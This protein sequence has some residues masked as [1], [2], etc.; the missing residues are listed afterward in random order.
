MVALGLVDGRV[1]LDQHVAGLDA[2]AV[3]DMDRA[4]HAGLERLDHLGAPARGRSCRCAVATISTVPRQAQASATQNRA[5]IGDADRAA[6][7][8]GRRL[9]DLERGRQE[10]QLVRAAG[11]TPVGTRPEPCVQRNVMDA[12]L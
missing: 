5:M 6:D 3:L 10:R 1:E 9:H 12:C 4:H 2:L 8:R 7:R 11:W